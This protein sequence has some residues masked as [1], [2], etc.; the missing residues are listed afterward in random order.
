MENN[1]IIELAK[2]LK[3]VPKLEELFVYQN[4]LKKEGL[5]KLFLELRNNCK[6]L[7]SFDLCDNFVREEATDE[8]YK[9]LQEST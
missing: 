9:L 8:L 1:G 5:S 7:N 2:S 6:L 3:F 4:T